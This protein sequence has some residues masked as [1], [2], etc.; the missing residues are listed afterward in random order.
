MAETSLKSVSQSFKILLFFKIQQ[1]N[2]K[3]F[4]STKIGFKVPKLSRNIYQVTAELFSGENLCCQ[5]STFLIR[6]LSTYPQ[7]EFIRKFT[8]KAVKN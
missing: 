6:L 3:P 7:D 4:L 2:H 1:I 5:I 8:R